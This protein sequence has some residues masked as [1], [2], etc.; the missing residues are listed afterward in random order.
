MVALEIT[1]VVILG[2]VGA[3]AL[4]T[5]EVPAPEFVYEVEPPLVF[6]IELGGYPKRASS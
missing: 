5:T 2:I 4:G 3:F 6:D 1:V